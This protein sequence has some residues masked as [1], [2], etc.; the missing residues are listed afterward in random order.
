VGVPVLTCL[1]QTFAG[2]VAASLLTAIDLPEL[3]ASTLEAYE[4]HARSLA[5]DGAELARLKAKLVRNRG[6]SA[7]FDTARI[8]R[9]LEAV[10]REM[11]ERQQRG[12]PPQSFA[13][14][15]RATPVPP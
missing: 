6:N 9:D 1:G 8:T 5:K 2:R 11:W 7:L 10:Y 12:E 13:V 4:A 14:V 15:A 3:I